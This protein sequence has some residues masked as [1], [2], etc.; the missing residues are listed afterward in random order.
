M[1]SSEL[2]A[3]AASLWVE[4]IVLWEAMTEEAFVCCDHGKSWWGAIRKCRDRRDDRAGLGISWY[5]DV[6]RH[7][8]MTR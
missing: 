1:S 7:M 2:S 4:A 5:P 3:G 8:D 6:P